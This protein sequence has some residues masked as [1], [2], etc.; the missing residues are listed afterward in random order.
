MATDADK[1]VVR[2]LFDEAI[3]QRRFDVFDEVV[4]ADFVLHSALLGEVRG[5][6]AYKQSVLGLLNPCPDLHATVE[7]LI[8]ADG[9]T[10]V[11]RLTYRGTD[12]GGFIRGHAATGKPFEFGA[13]YI[14]RLANGKLVELW[15]EADRMR[16]MQQLGVAG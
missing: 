15:Q 13:I 4:S 6:E 11:T 14:W 10:V 1:A 5:G 2:R 9:D 12:T 7:D 3:N 16:L 8:G